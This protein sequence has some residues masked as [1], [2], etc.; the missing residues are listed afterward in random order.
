M[1]S[2]SVAAEALAVYVDGVLDVNRRANEQAV[3]V[4][5]APLGQQ[6]DEA[7][8]SMDR[9]ERDLLAYQKTALIDGLRKDAEVALNQRARAADLRAAIAAERSRIAGAEKE[10]SVRRRQP[11]AP[12]R[13]LL[14][15]A[16]REEG[17]VGL[18]AQADRSP[19]RA[20]ESSPT[21]SVDPVYDVIDYQAASGRARAS[22]LEA[23]HDLL[24]RANVPE[25]LS[26]L[27]EAEVRLAR[28][29]M[30]H[31][32]ASDA[33]SQLVQ[34]SR[35]AKKAILDRTISV[36]VIDPVVAIRSPVSPHVWLTATVFGGTGLL[37]ALLV[38]A[39]FTYRPTSSADG[40]H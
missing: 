9:A 27:Y 22:A 16:T 25:T 26:R 3:S 1:S 4:A 5:T 6:I 12:A 36:E 14:D 24:S 39:A 7:K 28:L 10:L 21:A 30:E 34:Q 13:S 35:E 20:P 17:S 18:P 2:A 40:S 29:E 8:H 32:L 11:T 31:R 38:L 37:G 33:Y 23:E 15:F 19:A